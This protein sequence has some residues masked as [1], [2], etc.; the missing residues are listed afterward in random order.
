MPHRARP[1]AYRLRLAVLL[2]ALLSCGAAASG[3]FAGQDA[4]RR[5]KL[6][7]AAW[8]ANHVGQPVPEY[9]HGDECLF[10]HRHTI[11]A[12]WQQ[13]AHGT[14]VRQLEDAPALAALLKAPELSS[15]ASEIEYFLGSRHRV[16]FLKK[17]GYGKFALLGVQA[18]VSREGRLRGFVDAGKMRWDAA[19]FADACAGCHATGV[20]AK[21]KTFAAF[22]LDCYTCHGDVTLEHAKDTSLVWLSKKRRSDAQAVTA[23]CAQCHLRGGR[24]RS[25]GLPYPNNFIA[26]DNLFQDFDVDWSRADDPRLNPGE[27]HVWRSVRDVAVEGRDSPTCIT[28]HQVH[29]NSTARHKLPPR[30]PICF[31]CHSAEGPFKEVR[32]WKRSNATC[33]Y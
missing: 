12:T 16:R 10:C 28:C 31:D 18:E 7:P 2:A 33:E 23:I 22:G 1:L 6:D 29:A 3:Y 9:L 11:G 17:H 14:N 8:G 32:P 15:V 20:D 30:S 19:K 26:G 27:R 4:A 5:Q 21:T 13:N 24:S 25:T